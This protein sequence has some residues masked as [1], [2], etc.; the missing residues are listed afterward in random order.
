[1]ETIQPISVLSHFGSFRSFFARSFSPCSG[2]SPYRRWYVSYN[3]I[4]F[5]VLPFVPKPRS[6]PV[7]G[8]CVPIR[9]R[10]VCDHVP[11][12]VVRTSQWCSAQSLER[13]LT[14]GTVVD[15]DIIVIV[16]FCR[17]VPQGRTGNR[18]RGQII[19]IV[20]P[21]NRPSSRRRMPPL[22]NASGRVCQLTAL[23][24]SD[25]AAVSIAWL[26]QPEVWSTGNSLP[27]K[28]R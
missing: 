8:I 13:C 19:I 26:R 20:K 6:H 14:P 1:M 21:F 18:L 17:T 28:P 23:G 7:G 27:L 10:G 5:T 22:G 3:R 25:V 15:V 11:L 4:Q 16:D 9:R 12:G 24:S 2:H